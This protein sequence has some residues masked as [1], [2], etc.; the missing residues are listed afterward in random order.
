MP[1]V[2]SGVAG[3][4]SIGVGRRSEEEL[5]W[6]A[7]LG[8]RFGRAK[9]KYD[10]T[11][12][13][14]LPARPVP[15][16]PLTT[17]YNRTVRAPTASTSAVMP[18]RSLFRMFFGPCRIAIHRAFRPRVEPGVTVAPLGRDLVHIVVDRLVAIAENR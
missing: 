15:T 6:A 14:P 1:L 3:S 16:P 7:S 9:P 4:V 2:S 13:R 10:N 8:G 18:S 5:M 17:G 12:C 11:G